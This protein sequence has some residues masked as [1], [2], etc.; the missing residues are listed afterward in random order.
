VFTRAAARDRRATAHWGWHENVVGMGVSWKRERGARLAH[1]LCVTFFVLRKEPARRLLRRQRIPACL[2]LESVDARVLTDVVQVPGRCVAHAARVRP[3]R[4]RAEVGHARGGRGTLG[5]IVRRIGDARPLALSCSHVIARSGAIQDFGRTIEQPA[6][7]RGADA[8]G[9]LIDFTVLRAG[10]LATADVALAALSVEAFP[11]VLGSSIVPAAVSARTAKEF[12][13]GARTV[14][15][16]QVTNGA[17]GEVEAFESTWD[18]DEMPFVNGR[19]EFSGL[20]AY[21]TRSTR[22]DSGGLV[23]SGAKGEE[24]LVLGMHTAG[25]VDGRMG[26]FQ[27]IGPIMSRFELRLFGVSG[28]RGDR[29]TGRPL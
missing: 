4:P 20:V 13:V 29:P 8:V 15:F 9:R 16:G 12:D 5:P 18:I 7:G 6:G 26:L 28:N 2:D 27:P 1:V 22:G 17:R 23:M 24:S 25:R 11:A 3:V 19:V 21:R 14:L 10:T